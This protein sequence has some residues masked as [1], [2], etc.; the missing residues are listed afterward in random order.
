MSSFTDQA[1][2][3]MVKQQL[4]TNLV[5]DERLLNLIANI[6]REEFVPSEYRS[7]AYADL[8]IPIGHD[9]FMMN[10]MEEGQLLVALDIQPHET[11]LE[12]G[13]GTGYL[14]SLLA[15]LAKKVIS[16]DYFPEFTEAAQRRVGGLGLTNV[17]FITG[18]GCRGYLDRAPFDV[19]VSTGGH[20]HLPDVFMPQ[21]LTGGR[22]FALVGEPDLMVGQVLRVNDQQQWVRSWVF[23]TG[24]PLLIDRS[25]KGEFVF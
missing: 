2:V 16:I 11:V 13:T 9:Q 4:R 20:R 25:A 21:L 22:M 1:R 15:N 3:N 24:L 23:E 5:V 8:H 12:I 17:E 7:F 19:I 18:D 6:P 10:P 14:T